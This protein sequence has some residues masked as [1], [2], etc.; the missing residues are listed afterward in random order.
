LKRHARRLSRL[1]RAKDVAEEANDADTVARIDK[2][3]T[4]ENDR[5]TKWMGKFDAKA[6][7]GD[8]DK[9]GAK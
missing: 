9:A 7:G 6:A 1:E 8:K 5:H 3:I 4:K 2:L